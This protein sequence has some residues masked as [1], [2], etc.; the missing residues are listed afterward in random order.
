MCPSVPVEVYR[1]RHLA[2][3]DERAF[4]LIAVGVPSAIGRDGG[5]YQVFVEEASAAAAHGHLERYELESRPRPPLPPAP[6]AQPH[7][8]LGAAI[9]AAVLYGAALALGQGFGPLDAFWLGDL[10]GARVQSG[11][12]WRVFTALT[13]HLDIAHFMGNL[14]AGSLLGWLAGRRLGPGIAWALIL[15]AAAGAN[16]LE[17]CFGPAEHRSAGAST[18]VFAALGL[19]AAYEWSD[20]RTRPRP[21]RRPGRLAPLIAGVILLGFLGAGTGAADDTTD[22]VA[23]AAGFALGALCGALAARPGIR[24][25]LRH[26]P[27]WLAGTIALGAIVAAWALAIRCSTVS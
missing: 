5:L 14:G 17:A 2:D 4:M 11:E 3:C 13:L 27:Q 16:L 20:R 24:R 23:H 9:Y 18:A 8:W 6:P 26:V 19:L 21:V 1:S 10:S 7:A 12:W 25:A 22:L 15:I